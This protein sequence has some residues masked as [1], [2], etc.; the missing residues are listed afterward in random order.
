MKEP[1]ETNEITH[2]NTTDQKDKKTDQE[3]FDPKFNT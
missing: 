1:T 3:T 2:P